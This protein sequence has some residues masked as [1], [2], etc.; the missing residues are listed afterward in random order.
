MFKSKLRLLGVSALVGAGLIAT[1]PAK[2][3]NFSLGEVDMTIDTTLSVGASFVAADRETDY[4][5]ATNGGPVDQSIYF[6]EGAGLTWNGTENT[7][8]GQADAA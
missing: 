4:L 8:S 5:P 6:A 1:G 7:A 2:R 3:A